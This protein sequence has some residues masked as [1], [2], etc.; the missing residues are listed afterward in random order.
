[1]Q[2]WCGYGDWEYCR[3]RSTLR[4]WIIRSTFRVWWGRKMRSGWSTTS[5]HYCFRQRRQWRQDRITSSISSFRIYSEIMTLSSMSIMIPITSPSPQLIP[6]SP[7]KNSTINMQTSLSRFANWKQ[8]RPTIMQSYR[9][10]LNSKQFSRISN[11]IK[12][13][14]WRHTKP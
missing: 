2:G 10:R 5:A 12:V 3:T 8:K 13:N 1:M 9:M 6:N 4:I 7:N 11:Q 14:S